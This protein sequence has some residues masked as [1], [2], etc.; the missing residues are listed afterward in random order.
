M[1]KSLYKELWGLKD[2]E[3][4]S[5]L[6]KPK[7]F[8]AYHILPSEINYKLKEPKEI[9]DKDNNILHSPP[10]PPYGGPPYVGAQKRKRKR[11]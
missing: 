4:E 8:I 7:M 2:N 10:W 1:V 9:S 3:Y 6:S 5:I 11:E